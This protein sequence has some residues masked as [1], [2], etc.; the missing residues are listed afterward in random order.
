MVKDICL[1]SNEGS[2]CDKDYIPETAS[3]SDGSSADEDCPPDSEANND[4][5]HL[6][7]TI[8][9]SKPPHD[10]EH[11]VLYSD[12]C[13]GQNRNAGFSAMC[14]HAVKIL[15]ISMIDHTFMESGHS[16]MEYD[17]VHAAIETARKK[18]PVYSPEGYYTL[19]RMARR[20]RPYKVI[21][22]WHSDFLDFKSFSQ[23]TVRNRT[24]DTEGQ[25]VR[26]QKMKWLRHTKEYPKGIQFK[27][28]LS[29]QAASWKAGD[30]RCSCN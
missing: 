14:L 6:I 26:W 11:V 5:D 28:E 3:S 22:L 27:Y 9:D 13:G 2:F 24:K 1:S 7:A 15:P 30:Q 18:L 12:T 20:N 10:T 21:E 8:R 16:Q 17:S 19:V 25:T 23:H 29:N 4:C